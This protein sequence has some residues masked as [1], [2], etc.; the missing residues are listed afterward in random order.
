[1]RAP[2]DG[3]AARAGAPT[4]ALS[5]PP[6]SARFDTVVM[7]P[8]FGT[9]SAGADVAFLGTALALA[10]VVYSLHKT[11]TRDFLVRKAGEL[12]ARADVLAELKFDVPKSYAFHRDK[13]RDVLVDL[14]RFSSLRA[15]GEG[16]S[17]SGEERGAL[18]GAATAASHERA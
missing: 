3:G 16:S 13:S 17:R 8:P 9:R 7:N 1:M 5:P 15:S 6:N 12:G 14:V 10:P 18:R 2:R 11:T 4:D